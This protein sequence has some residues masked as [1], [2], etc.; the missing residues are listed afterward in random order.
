[1]V[2]EAEKSKIRGLAWSGSGEG[3]LPDLKMAAFSLCPPLAGKE[4][5]SL[6]SLLLTTNPLHE[7]PT[8]TISSKPNYLL[9]GSISKYR[10]A[11]D[12]GLPYEFG[13]GQ[14]AHTQLSP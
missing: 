3:S 6:V 12:H 9:K 8:F 7:G 5:S 2:L 11:G 10:P 4:G 14:G 1:M 13:G